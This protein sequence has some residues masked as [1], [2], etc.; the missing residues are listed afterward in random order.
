LDI[1][2]NAFPGESMKN[3]MLSTPNDPFQLYNDKNPYNA[4]ASIF[5]IQNFSRT[6][7][8]PFPIFFPRGQW[9]FKL[10]FP[11]NLKINGKRVSVP[12]A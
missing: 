11:F 5:S 10:M 4:D 3:I 6:S 9:W 12:Q 1:K 2:A 7:L 8:Y